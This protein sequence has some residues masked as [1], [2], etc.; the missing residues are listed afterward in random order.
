MLTKLRLTLQLCGF[1]FI[2]S[3]MSTALATEPVRIIFD[4]DIGNDVD[5]ALALALLHEL[6][7]RGEAQILA[8][9]IS[10]DNDW[11][12]P[13]IDAI[14]TFYGRPDIPI[15]MIQN[16]KTPEPGKFNRE[17]ADRHDENGF[18]YPHDLL[19]GSDAPEVIGLL[20]KTLAS[21]PDGSVVMVSVG[22]LTNMA[23]LIT[24]QPDA[25]SN[26]NGMD[27]VKTKI[28]LYVPMAGAFSPEREPEYNVHVD[29]DASR[30]VFQ[31]WPTPIV[32]S[33]FEIG[34]AVPYPA[35]SIEHDFGYVKNHPI[36]EAYRHYLKMPYDRPTWDLTAVLYAVRPNRGYF[37]LSYPGKI[38]LNADK[39]TEFT[40]SADGKHRF[41]ILAPS[42]IGRLEQLLIDLVSSPPGK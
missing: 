31:N 24:S 26:L 3:L 22:F 14:N 28:R 9:T 19:S 10:K 8:V 1:V 42:N 2:A 38:S 33:G 36:A 13:H 35:S 21:Q 40:E 20:R 32:A 25:H 27:L 15:G 7:D 6:A 41:M 16:G 30:E 17:I 4:T 11:T 23:R 29:I 34:L 39:V 5:D 18:I 12:V 37:T